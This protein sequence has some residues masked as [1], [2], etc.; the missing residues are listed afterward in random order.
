MDAKEAI[1]V[2]MRHVQELFGEDGSAGVVRG[3][4][5]EEVGADDD[6]NWLVTVS[7]LPSGADGAETGGT[8]SAATVVGID[9]QLS[10]KQVTVTQDGTVKSIKLRPIV[11]G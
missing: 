1:R 9:L 8:S 5:L 11:V 6:G 10:Y 7:F 2:A 3:L 4:R